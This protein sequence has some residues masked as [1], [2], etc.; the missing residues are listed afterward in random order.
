MIDGDVNT[1][2]AVL[3]DYINATKGFVE[4]GRSLDKS[5]KSL[6]R[7]LGPS[8]NP[9]VQNMFAIISRLRHKEGIRF[10]IKIHN[11]RSFKRN[12]SE[13]ESVRR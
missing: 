7:M 1:G 13:S 6:M 8:G 12:R 9:G 10:A 2:K 3:R 5:P 11:G 4:L